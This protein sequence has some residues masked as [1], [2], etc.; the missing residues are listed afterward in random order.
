[1]VN[2][3]NPGYVNPLTMMGNG[4]DKQKYLFHTEG[5]QTA[6]KKQRAL[7]AEKQSIENSLLLMKGTSG[8]AGNS[9]EN[10][11]LLEKK[12]E[13]ITKEL[14]ISAREA[15]EGSILNEKQLAENNKDSS[16]RKKQRLDNFELQYSGKSAE[17][18]KIAYDEKG[19]RIVQAWNPKE[20]IISAV[21]TDK[22]EMQIPGL[23]IE[24]KQIAMQEIQQYHYLRN[25]SQYLNVFEQYAKGEIGEYDFKAYSFAFGRTIGITLET[26]TYVSGLDSLVTEMK[27]NISKGI[28][29][30]PDNLK[31]ELWAGGLSLTWKELMNLQKTG[32]YIDK[33][34]GGT[35]PGSYDAYARAGIAKAYIYKPELGL[36]NKQTS[37]LKEA[38]EKKID[39]KLENTKA[40]LELAVSD[41]QNPMW[42]GYYFGGTRTMPVA[43]DTKLISE[44]TEAFSRIDP[45]NR[46]SY[47][48]AVDRFQ[49]L[50]RPW[51]TTFASYVARQAPGYAKSYA[52]EKERNS[53]A[54]FQAIWNGTY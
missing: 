50:M 23:E 9:K 52:Q 12:L 27:E 5:F 53:R 44:I 39:R 3:V 1:M 25:S 47:D 26:D 17:L 6:E 48:T 34:F 13:E 42:E 19:Q 33:F 46:Q 18:Y 54:D 2:H 51:N 28:A 10:I 40:A 29:N 35:S 38:V 8:D 16:T 43:S 31:T 32:E 21:K 11:E 37:I 15:A 22:D 36:S 7:E 30:T 49:E 20:E 45:N 14:H 4:K 41:T 24:R